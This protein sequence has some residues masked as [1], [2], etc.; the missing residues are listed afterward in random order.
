MTFTLYSVTAPDYYRYEYEIN[1]LVGALAYNKEQQI[2]AQFSTYKANTPGILSSGNSE[3][4]TID[5]LQLGL[6]NEEYF[7]DGT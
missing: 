4:F 5:I 2:L 7:T 3:I 6:L 1:G